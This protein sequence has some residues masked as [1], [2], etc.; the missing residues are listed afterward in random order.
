MLAFRS[1]AN[2]QLY[3]SVESKT[4]VQHTILL[5]LS[6]LGTICIMQAGAS[7]GFLAVL[8]L[9]WSQ[10]P[11]SEIFPDDRGEMT[12]ILMRAYLG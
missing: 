9:S 8:V 2:P 5:H 11:N 4:A 12:R 10:E 1:G 6:H 7:E 3:D